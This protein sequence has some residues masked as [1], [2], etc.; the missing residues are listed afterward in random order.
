MKLFTAILLFLLPSLSQ[1]AIIS[2]SMFGWEES[3]TI[4]SIGDGSNQVSMWWSINTSDRGWFYGSGNALTRSDVALATGVTDISQ[5]TDASAFSFTNTFVGPVCDADCNGNGVGD[6]LVWRN[7]DSGF[8][9]V[10]RVDDIDTTYGADYATLSGTWWFQTDGSA[11]FSVVPV[12]A[13]AWFMGSAL[14][15]LVGVG[16]R[17]RRKLV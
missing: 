6:F 2:G 4:E 3:T 12:P 1:A 11:N 10:L 16:R 5:I 7:I 15:A 9:G 14:A 17:R 13:A 8:Y